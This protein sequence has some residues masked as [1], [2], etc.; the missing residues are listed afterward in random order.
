[1]DVASGAV[2]KLDLGKLESGVILLIGAKAQ[3]LTLRNQII[4]ALTGK[5][6][7]CIAGKL[8]RCIAGKLTRCIAGDPSDVQPFRDSFCMD[9]PLHDI[10]LRDIMT[11]QAKKIR[12]HGQARTVPIY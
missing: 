10:D 3:R 7:R 9:R 1:M 4:P 8:T 12:K 2:S 11:F 5:L 6:T